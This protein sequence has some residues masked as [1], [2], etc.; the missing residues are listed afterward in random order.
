MFDKKSIEIASNAQI[1]G[2]VFIGEKRTEISITVNAVESLDQLIDVLKNTDGIDGVTSVFDKV[3]KDPELRKVLHSSLAREFG[4]DLK[5][6]I[7]LLVT[8]LNSFGLDG[9]DLTK[10]NSLL[11]EARDR[12]DLESTIYILMYVLQFVQNTPGIESLYK[13]YAEEIIGSSSKTANGLAAKAVAYSFRAKQ[14]FY[15]F[16]S[17][18]N[19]N[20]ISFKG[21]KDCSG[22]YSVG[23]LKVITSELLE[24]RLSYYEDILTAVAMSVASGSR[25]AFLLVF[26]TFLFT[27]EM[28]ATFLKVTGE[29]SFKAIK[30]DIEKIYDD[31][32]SMLNDWNLLGVEL[33]DLNNN[34][35]T[36]YLLIEEFEAGKKFAS[37]AMDLYL[38]NG[39]AFSAKMA[40]QTLDEAGK[41]KSFEVELEESPI[42]ASIEEFVKFAE[43]N[44]RRMLRMKGI[45]LDSDIKLKKDF[46]RA[47]KNMQPSIAYKHCEYIIVSAVNTPKIGEELGLVSMGEMLVTCRKKDVQTRAADIEDAFN[48]MRCFCCLG[49]RDHRP[50]AKDWVY[51]PQFEIE[52]FSGLDAKSKK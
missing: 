25:E 27:F 15:A 50:R 34:K 42:E 24:L 11:A 12:N 28:D 43:D 4:K 13:D 40:K 7:D 36:F 46:E 20:Y 45:D 6:S 33:A 8:D 5:A 52:L 31:F 14:K 1:L 39:R 2:D 47:L 51:T 23:A 44:A 37:V 19:I 26:N 10:L 35:A 21:I 49:C 3:L 48:Q 30:E 17:H 41:K 9:L 38:E 29:V 22:E 16:N 18:R 32:E